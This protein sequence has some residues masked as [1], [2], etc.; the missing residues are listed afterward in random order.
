MLA[1]SRRKFLGLDRAEPFQ[2]NL[3]F[4]LGNIFLLNPKHF[5]SC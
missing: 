5:W 2:R 1:S 3:C 4:L